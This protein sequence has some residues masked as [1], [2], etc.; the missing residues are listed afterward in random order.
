MAPTL[1]VGSVSVVWDVRDSPAH[2]RQSRHSRQVDLTAPAT[3][4]LSQHM[5]LVSQDFPWTIDIKRN[6]NHPLTVLDI[7]EALYEGLGK[8]VR[9]SEWAL[10]TNGQ[11]YAIQKSNKQRRGSETAT[12]IRRVD[13]LPRYMFRGLEKDESLARKRLMP[14]DNSEGEMWAVRFGS[15]I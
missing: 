7:I 10:A 8:E 1:A 9:R 3:S 13:W 12:R 5:R 14:G 4:T 15:W 6:G 11:K 2:M